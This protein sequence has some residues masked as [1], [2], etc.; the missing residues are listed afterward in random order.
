MADYFTQLAFEI[1]LPSESLAIAA[2][3]FFDL[4]QNAIYGDIEGDE[5]P[6]TIPHSAGDYCDTGID[7]T[8]TDNT[9]QI[10]D[11][12]GHANVDFVLDF[13]QEVL[14][15]F[16]PSADIGFE[17]ANTCSRAASNGFGG[18]A[19]FVTADESRSIGTWESIDLM[20][21]SHMAKHAGNVEGGA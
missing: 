20:R 8:R 4:W 2:Y 10:T 6:E 15:R 1:E 17:W 9:L 16:N 19:A 5:W 14:K 11:G 21:Q 18:G 13:V 3:D 7:V 12:D